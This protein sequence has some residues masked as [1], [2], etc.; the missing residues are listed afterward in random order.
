MT[1]IGT[2][3][4]H[5]SLWKWSHTKS[6]LTWK[7]KDRQV[8]NGIGRYSQKK[9]RVRGVFCTPMEAARRDGSFKSFGH[10]QSQPHETWRAV[11]KRG[12]K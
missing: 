12:G 8:K 7:A 1:R 2:R 11:L 6:S 5:D 10:Y 4:K 3:L 9:K